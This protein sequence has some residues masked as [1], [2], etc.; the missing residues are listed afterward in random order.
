[1]SGR[2][3]AAVRSNEMLGTEVEMSEFQKVSSKADLDNLDEADI[4]AGYIAGL[5]GANEP[6][7]DK[8]RGYWHGWRNGMVDS[9][10][11][12]KDAEQASLAVEIVRAHRA[13]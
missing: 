11:S 7:S 6:G 12:D 3:F 5:D 1:M 2:R 10:R 8:S 4:V 9:G 13:H